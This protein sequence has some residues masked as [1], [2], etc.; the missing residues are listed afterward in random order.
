MKIA[1]IGGGASGLITA[2]LLHQQHEVT[3]YEKKAVL[4]GKVRTLNKNVLGTSVPR[5]VAIENGVLG[6]SESYLSPK[7]SSSFR[8]REG[9]RRSLAIML[10]SGSRSRVRGI[11]RM[12]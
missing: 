9:P 6:F 7:S 10:P 4:G 12:L 8:S 2:Y 3:V 11:E 1:I 5:E